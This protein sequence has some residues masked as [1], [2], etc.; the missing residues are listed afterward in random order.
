M[1]Y[2]RGPTKS[3]SKENQSKILNKIYQTY[4]V[5]TPYILAP[6]RFDRNFREVILKLILM[7]DC[8]RAICE[9]VIR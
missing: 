7:V 4:L 8:W 1:E 6:G 9:I 5:S 2:P 3:I